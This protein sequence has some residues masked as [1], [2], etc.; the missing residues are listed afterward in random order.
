MCKDFSEM[1]DAE[2]DVWREERE[3]KRQRREFG[4]D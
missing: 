4:D 2:R 1:S 3:E